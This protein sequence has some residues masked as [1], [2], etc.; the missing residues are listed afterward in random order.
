MLKSLYDNARI[1]P[2]ALLVSSQ[3][4]HNMALKVGT[5][6]GSD[7]IQLVQQV[8]ADG[9]IQAGLTL[10]FYRNPYFGGRPI[11]VIVHPFAAPGTILAI[12]E[13]LPFPNTNVP[14]PF[15][16]DVALGYTQYDWALVQRKWEFGVYGRQA[17]KVYFPAGCGVITGIKNG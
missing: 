13:A 2:T 6:S 10:T 16:I 14:N 11:P 3:E 12:S 1:S 15:E 4:G 17:L 5:G 8:G 9:T 7:H